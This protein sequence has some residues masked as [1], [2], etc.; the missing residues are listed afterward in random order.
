M[1]KYETKTDNDNIMLR[2]EIAALRNESAALRN[3]NVALR[4][5]RDAMRNERDALATEN[6]RLCG[7]I[8]R[9]PGFSSGLSFLDQPR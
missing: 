7:Q 3:E 8:L 9:G 2:S 6:A 5:E 4:N 1:D